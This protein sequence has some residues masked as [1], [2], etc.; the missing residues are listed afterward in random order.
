M[1]T[2]ANGKHELFAQIW[3]ETENKSEAY[4]TAYPKSLKWQD[5]TV[6]TKASALSKIGEVQGRYNELKHEAAVGHG[7]TIE[8][9]LQ[10]LDEAKAMAEF[11]ARSIDNAKG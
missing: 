9:L 4:R 10:E 6:H 7:V 5:N 3:H 8:T 1:P 2:L 11:I